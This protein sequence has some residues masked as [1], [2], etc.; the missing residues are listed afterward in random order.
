MS[1]QDEE[2]ALELSLEH[3]ITAVWKST[4]VIGSMVP[5]DLKHSNFGC[6]KGV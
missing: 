1:K 3:L 5:S 2:E 6:V 4:H